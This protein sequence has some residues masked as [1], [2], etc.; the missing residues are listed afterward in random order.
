MQFPSSHYNTLKGTSSILTSIWLVPARVGSRRS[1]VPIRGTGGM[2][3]TTNTTRH[4]GIAILVIN[5]LLSDRR[6][7]GC[8]RRAEISGSLVGRECIR[9]LSSKL[10]IT[11]LGLALPEL[12]A[13]G[14]GGV[15]VVGG[16]TEGF[17]LLVVADKS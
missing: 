2:R 3:N 13:G 1:L 6:G 16:W 17:L 14:A 15:A 4:I 8:I 9:L 12:A 10:S 5:G 11:V 7:I